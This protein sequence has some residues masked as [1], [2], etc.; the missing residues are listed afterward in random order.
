M[1]HV[2]AFVGCGKCLG[3]NP[4]AVRAVIVDD[5]NMSTWKC[6]QRSFNYPSKIL[7]LVKSGQN[8]KRANIRR[9]GHFANRSQEMG[10]VQSAVFVRGA[11]TTS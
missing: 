7:P 3:E 4:G 5:K 6:S 9:R 11:V 10:N 8:D 1:H 2:D